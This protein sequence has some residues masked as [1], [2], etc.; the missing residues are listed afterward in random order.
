MWSVSSGSN[1]R[2]ISA[3]ALLAAPKLLAAPD[4]MRSDNAKSEEMSMLMRRICRSTVAWFGPAWSRCG[5]AAF[6]CWLWLPHL[7][8][9]AP[10]CDGLVRLMDGWL[11]GWWFIDAVN[12]RKPIWVINLGAC[13]LLACLLPR[14]HLPVVLLWLFYWVYLRD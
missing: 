7:F 10:F 5:W 3:W 2:G 8:A 14:F 12:Q 1:G 13:L 11:V 4:I 6:F 9:R